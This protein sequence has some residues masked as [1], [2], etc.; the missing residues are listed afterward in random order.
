ML[1]SMG[2]QVVYPH[3]QHGSIWNINM[4]ELK[5]TADLGYKSFVRLADFTSHNELSYTMKD[6]NVVVSCI[7]S[8]MYYKTEADFEESNIRI[9]VAIAKAAKANPR[10]KRLIMIGQAGADPNSASRKLRTKWV[11]EQ[12]VKEIYPEVTFLRPT[13]MFNTIQQNP[14]LSG[15]WMYQMKM[16]NR[17]NFVADG[18]NAK[19]QPVFSDDVAQAV[20]NSLKM[21]ESIGQT[22]DLGGPHVY[23][24][25][26]MY[27]MFANI[28]QIKPY[29]A[30]YPLER[31]YEEWHKNKW[32]SFWKN[33]VRY[34][35]T[36]EFIGHEGT[37]IVCDPNVKGFED[38][39]IKPVS[40]GQK[41]PE[42][43]AEV[44]WLYNSHQVTKREAANS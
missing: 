30:V 10:I 12:A 28:C 39:H 17:M 3:R 40:F 7:G 38:L 11:G 2:S 27:E 5:V 1:T 29:S 25:L 26:E 37:E 21:E 32:T 41:A 14:T 36:P 42:Y 23:T 6:S 31:F 34:H 44:Y 19:F 22:Y 33:T 15:K 43:V 16:F 35:M 4:R 8:K 20:I 24:Y 13:V 9:P 18:M